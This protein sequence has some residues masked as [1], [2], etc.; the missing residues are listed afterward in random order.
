MRKVI[1]TLFTIILTL[2]LA[3][4]W[5]RR[6]INELALVIAKGIDLTNN[7]QV[8]CSM[9]VVIPS[10]VGGGQSGSGKGESGKSFFVVTGTG[11]TISEADAM[12]QQKLSRQLYLPHLRLT[13][14]GD[15][16]ARDGLYKY[17]DIF[18]R[19]PP[20][21]LR[22]AVSIAK[23][24]DALSLLETTSP[25]ESISGENVR[26]LE[27]QITG[28]NTTMMDFLIAASSEGTDQYASAVSLISPSGHYP[29]LALNNQ[30]VFRDLK[31]V[32]YLDRPS[33]I[34][35]LW[36]TERLRYTTL[37]MKVPKTDGTIS[38]D[39]TQARRRGYT[40]VKGNQVSVRYEL[41][42]SAMITENT[43]GLDSDDPQTMKMFENALNQYVV[44]ICKECLTTLFKQY[45]ADPTGVGQMVYH[46]HPYN[47][48][49]LKEK[50]RDEIPNIQYDIASQVKIIEAGK[51]GPPLYGK[52][53]RGIRTRST[54]TEQLGGSEQ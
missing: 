18:G 27:R 33:S 53:Q 16:M 37:T 50:W 20:I 9:Q 45:D 13:L 8:R 48:E 34:A 52:P 28:T 2:P 51:S 4:C 43:T 32:G 49:R 42:G 11:H 3:G 41:A 30:A 47:W 15:R 6:E 10:K 7:N 44:Q 35:L 17:L 24:S 5:D 46:Q 14:I 19:N 39:L 1:L 31:L 54:T 21:R 29:Y 38:V 22:A 25:L 23:D 26:K 36:L 40:Y 12:I